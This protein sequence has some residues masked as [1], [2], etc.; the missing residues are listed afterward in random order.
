[1]RRRAFLGL[2]SVAMPFAVFAQ[3]GRRKWHISVLFLGSPAS[4]LAQ[5]GIPLFRQRLRELGYTE[6]NTDIEE[7]YADGDQ[8]RLTKLAQEV[9]ARN[10]DVIVAQAVAATIAARRATSIIPIVMLHAGDPIGA[11]LIHNLAHPGG[12][13]TGTVNLPLG[14]K[15]VDL[16]R[17]LLPNVA[18]VAILNNPTS[19]AAASFI[20][21]I[22]DAARKSRMSVTVAQVTKR[23]DFPA[24]FAVIRAAQPDA[25]LVVVE[26]LIAQ[27]DGTLIEF[28]AA[29]R[30]P[31]IYDGA[32]QVR[33]GGLMAYAVSYLE[34]YPLAADY[35]DKILKGERAAELPVQ[36]PKKFELVINL[37][38]ANALGVTIPQSLLVRADEVIR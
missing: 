30:L 35:V 3:Q 28:A 14:G 25:L 7:R 13:I 27:Y 19:A 34:H 5:R 6:I 17:E 32:A 31:T 37:K 10:V 15:L 12:N 16:V 21:T 33:R 22:D 24:A 38:T 36:Q 26:P 9:A 8:G 18:K 1:M 20:A 29:A 2:A 23:E 4:F 11:G